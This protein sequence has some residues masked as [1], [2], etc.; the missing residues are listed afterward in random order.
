MRG[1]CSDHKT[2]CWVGGGSVW[3]FM[4][5]KYFFSKYCGAKI[6]NSKTYGWIENVSI[7]YESRSLLGG[8]KP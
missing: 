7:D 8:A 5:K 6:H 3:V 4:S 1:V 2:T